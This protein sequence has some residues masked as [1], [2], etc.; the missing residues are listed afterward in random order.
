MVAES[1]RIL[2]V[3]DEA[4]VARLLY[5]RLR[6]RGYEVLIADEGRSA[7]ASAQ[8]F[9]PDLVILDLMLP[10]TDG[11]RVSEELR[12][13]MSSCMVPILMLTARTEAAD[14]LHGFSAGADAYLTKPYDAV[15]LL[16]TVRRLLDDARRD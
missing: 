5:A 9:R 13:R 8:E 7:L 14:K 16:A 15:E 11:Y 2:V 12:R 10:D 6:S 1:R 3:E 4:D